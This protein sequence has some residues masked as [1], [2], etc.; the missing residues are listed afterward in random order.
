M[1]TTYSNARRLSTTAKGR[2][3]PTHTK[4]GDKIVELNLKV[5]DVSA[6]TGIYTRTMTEYIAGRKALLPKH[7][8]A[9]ARF[10]ECDPED[11]TGLVEK[12]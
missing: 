1:A 6:H 8:V 5:A 12:A 3:I 7:L 11:I 2:P 4:L 9:L 10:L